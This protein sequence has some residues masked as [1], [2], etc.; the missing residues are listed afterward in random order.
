MASAA[1]ND[2]LRGSCTCGRINYSILLPS[3]EEAT[4]TAQQE[5]EIFVD[6]RTEN[7]YLRVPIARYHSFTT[8]FYPDE[9]HSS[10]RRT[11]TPEHARQFHFSSLLLNALRFGPPSLRA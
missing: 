10:I 6:D 4:A 1:T 2:P 7:A 3:S 5:F 11:F 8:A 9:T